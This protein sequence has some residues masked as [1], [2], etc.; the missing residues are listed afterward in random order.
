MKIGFPSFLCGKTVHVGSGFWKGLAGRFCSVPVVREIMFANAITWAAISSVTP[1]PGRRPVHP[2][3][4][5]LAIPAELHSRQRRM[6][7]ALEL[8]KIEVAA[9]F[10][11]SEHESFDHPQRRM[12]NPAV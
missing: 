1:L 11:G 3:L 6:Q 7:K 4:S 10:A 5:D 8:E 12:G 9:R 2:N